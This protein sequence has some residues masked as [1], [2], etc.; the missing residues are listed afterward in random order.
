[1]N[2]KK[3]AR[4]AFLM[5]CQGYKEAIKITPEPEKF[6]LERG[7]KEFIKQNRK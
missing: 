6:R 4:K 7:L 2:K 3:E 1:M 5:T